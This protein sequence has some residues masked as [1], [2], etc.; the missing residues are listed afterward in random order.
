MEDGGSR[1]NNIRPWILWLVIACMVVTLIALFWPKP[2]RAPIANAL[3]SPAV[4][5]GGDSVTIASGQRVARRIAE[6]HARQ[7]GKSAEEI[8][9]EK[10]QRFSRSRRGI[11]ERI[12]QRRKEALP[13][14]I[15]AF[16][17]AVDKG[18]W[19][20]I[21]SRWKEL[22][23]YRNNHERPDLIPY[24]A[25][26][27]DTY[28][29]AEQTHEWPA[30]QLLDYGNAMLGS[31]R[32]GMVYVG[33]TDCG[34]FVPELMSETS[35]D[36][37][38]VITQNALADPT[39]L[40]LLTDLY[41]GQL[42]GLS[43]DDSQRAFQDYMADAQKRLQHDL[44]FP[45]EPKQVLPGENIAM[46]DGH[47]EISGDVAVMAVNE[48]LLQALMQKNPDLSFALEESFALRTTYPDAL[49]LGPLMELNAP[50]DQTPFNADLAA[51][52]VDYWRSTAQT[53]LADPEAT[54]SEYALKAY[55]HD[56]DATA[57]LLASHN[58]TS[59]AE[60]AYRLATQV[61]PSNAEA[62]GG[63][64]KVLV[65]NGHADQAQLL[66]DQFASK[67][68]DQTKAIEQAKAS[69]VWK[70]N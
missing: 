15:A 58:F 14:E 64:A 3:A 30:Q 39:Y 24:L 62:A 17:D 70:A 4:N 61:W 22:L 49:P 53:L 37:H 43:T 59:Q 35:D 18:D 26:V 23:A 50:S 7:P 66:L 54:G 46:K 5:H 38:M 60:E 25:T 21:D 29:T 52:S 19:N 31:L 32:P 56:I 34:R 68:P 16:F 9:A 11:V 69:I 45:N 12:A 2:K 36:P 63:L 27:R 6:A 13:P 41:G 33:G 1:D 57:N 42:N 44:D 47:L 48:K 40:D 51:Q 8:V 28:G 55:S 65:Q 67:Y 10:L 20:E